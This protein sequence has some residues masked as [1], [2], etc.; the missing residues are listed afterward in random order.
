MPAPACAQ[1]SFDP[2]AADCSVAAI[3][4]LGAVPLLLKVLC[5]TTGMG[6]AAVARVTDEAWTA[7][8]VRDVIHFGL[9]P[10]SSLDV[11]TTLCI[12]VKSSRKP[13]VIEHASA[14]PKYCDHPTPQRYHFE[15]YVSVPI[16][17]PNG[18]YFGN[19]CA[20]DPQPAKVSDPNIVSMFEDFAK[21]IA[22]QLSEQN[23]QDQE[24]AALLDERAV[25]ELREQ[26]I[27]VLGHDLRN[28][29]QALFATCDLLARRHSDEWSMALVSRMKANAHRMSTLIDDV[30]DFARGRLGGGFGVQIQTAEHVDQGLDAVVKE[31]QGSRPERTVVSHIH[32][33][34]AV[35]C[36]VGRIQQLASNLLS[37]ALTHGAPTSPVT[38][39]VLADDRELVI[40]VW[41]DGEPIPPESLG[42]IFSPFWRRSTSANRDGLGLGLHICSEIVHAHGGHLS[43]TSSKEAGTQ[44]I[45]RIPRSDVTTPS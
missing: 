10:G 25:S 17:L 12:D 29:L 14:D 9:I 37:N 22:Y 31:L 23:R 1:P 30:L 6:F 4:S 3:A 39:S 18:D 44:F 27:A 34:Q 21:L 15:S 13:I 5:D 41:N 11:D 24:H 45:A 33:Q 43:V 38:F 26:F 2:A 35:R 19:L 8:A 40:K 20:I 28:P 16:E 7:C 36:D 32:V 42:K